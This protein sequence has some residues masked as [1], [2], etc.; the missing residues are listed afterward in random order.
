VSV[1]AVAVATVGATVVCNVG[2]NPDAVA[3]AVAG[4][5]KSPIRIVGTGAEAVADPEPGKTMRL[6]FGFNPE[7]VADAAPGGTMRFTCGPNADAV[8][9]ATAGGTTSRIVGPRADAVA[10]ATDGGIVNTTCGP[11]AEPVLP[12]TAGWSIS[13]NV[14]VSADAVAPATAGVSV[15]FPPTA[16]DGIEIVRSSK[17]ANGPDAVGPSVKYVWPSDSNNCD[18][19]ICPKLAGRNVAITPKMFPVSDTN[20]GDDVT[21]P[22]VVITWYSTYWWMN[23]VDAFDGPS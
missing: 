17:N 21:V 18:W 13:I 2:T 3:D 22:A 10:A 1:E 16:A 6:M 8:A 9:F 14:G 15:M 12:A 4:R 5:M 20:V 11:T 7:P 19:S 23:G